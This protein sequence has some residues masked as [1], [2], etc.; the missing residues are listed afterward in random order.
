M[1][2]SLELT[3][4]RFTGCWGFLIGSAIQWYESLDKHP[5]E[6]KENQA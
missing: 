5:V 1:V 3:F 6:R 4:M 2:S